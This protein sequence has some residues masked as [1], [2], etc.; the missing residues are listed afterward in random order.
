M[1]FF[2]QEYWIALPFPPPGD[3]LDSGVQFMPPVSP[4]MA[5]RF[6]STVPP[7]K[8]YI[9]YVSAIKKVY[10]KI[11]CKAQKTHIHPEF[12]NLH[13]IISLSYFDGFLVSTLTWSCQTVR[14]FFCISPAH[15]L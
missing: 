10:S 8:P 9:C 11:E 4:A 14:T 13:D 6:L 7:G 2:R 1:G 5:C 3:L 15:L 12:T